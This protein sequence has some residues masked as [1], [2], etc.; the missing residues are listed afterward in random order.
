MASVFWDKRGIIHVDF[1]P[2]GA[3]N[4]EY[5]CPVLSDGHMC[6]RK[7]MAWFDHQGRPASP[8]QCMSSYCSPHYV[9]IT[10]TRLGGIVTSPLQPGPRSK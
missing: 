7:K 5:Y 6:L 1:L 10:A 9:H 8:G 4:S 3:I 2:H